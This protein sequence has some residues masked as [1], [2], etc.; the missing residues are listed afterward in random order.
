MRRTVKPVIIVAAIVIVLG[1]LCIPIK[2]GSLD[3]LTT[4]YSAV[5]W[6]CTDYNRINTDGKMEKGRTIKILSLTVYDVG[7]T[8]TDYIR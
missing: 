5:L 7:V 6:S 8:N 2:T 1:V 3:G 4:T